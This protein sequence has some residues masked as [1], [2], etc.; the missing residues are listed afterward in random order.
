[1]RLH[2]EFQFPWLLKLLFPDSSIASFG[3]CFHLLTYPKQIAMATGHI[4]KHDPTRSLQVKGHSDLTRGF[5]LFIVQTSIE[6]DDQTHERSNQQT[7]I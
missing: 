5:L 6:H 7:S 3:F 1:M 2:L 4:W